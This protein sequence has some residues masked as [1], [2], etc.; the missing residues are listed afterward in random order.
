MSRPLDE[1]LGTVRCPECAEQL[2]YTGYDDAAGWLEKPASSE[3][4]VVEIPPADETLTDVLYDHM[5]AKHPDFEV[6]RSPTREDMRARGFV[7]YYEY[8]L[9]CRAALVATEDLVG[10]QLDWKIARTRIAE[11]RQ[12]RHLR[13]TLLKLR[14]MVRG[15]VSPDQLLAAIEDGLYNIPRPAFSNDDAN[16]GVHMNIV[17]ADSGLVQP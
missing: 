3:S 12:I 1:V 15:G 4:L 17:I 6:C 9:L 10:D 5:E 14:S 8:F 7:P 13:R 16:S 2:P 11:L